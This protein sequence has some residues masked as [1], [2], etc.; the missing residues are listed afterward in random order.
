MVPPEGE[1]YAVPM[2]QF[3][4]LARWLV[5][6]RS[7]AL[8]VFAEEGVYVFREGPSVLFHLPFLVSWES[9]RSVKKRNILGVYPHYVMDVE[10]DAAGK[11]RLRLRMEVKAELER[12]YRPMRAAAAE[13]SPVR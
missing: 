6:Y 4:G 9:V 11:M 2:L 10:D 13:L 3:G 1:A 8:V 12:Y 5:V 7:S